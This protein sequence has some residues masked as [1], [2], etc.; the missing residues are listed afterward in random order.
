MN[1]ASMH[2][3]MARKGSDV[4]QISHESVE[5]DRVAEIRHRMANSFQLLSA[6]TRRQLRE[7]ETP[8]A[9]SRLALVLDQILTV[10][11]LQTGLS[12]AEDG[13]LHR[14]LD[15]VEQLWRQIAL[16]HSIEISVR[17]DDLSGLSRQCTGAIALILQEAVTNCIKHAYPA[18]MNVNGHIDIEVTL[19]SAG[20]GRLCVSDDGDG[21][22]DDANLTKSQGCELIRDLASEIGGSVR[23][24]AGDN[25][26]TVLTVEFPAGPR[27]RARSHDG[28]NPH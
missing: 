28:G 4:T 12:I 10:S 25:G 16:P 22:P 13:G 23:W 19:S 11:Q 27:D 3:E 1:S 24:T 5:A 21:M 9:R 18:A 8:E 2:Q 17:R 6:H 26:G 15:G 7:A 20:A 14:Y